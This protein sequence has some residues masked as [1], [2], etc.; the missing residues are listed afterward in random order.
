MLVV[1]VA[2]DVVK[3]QPFLLGG[4]RAFGHD[5]GGPLICREITQA[6]DLAAWASQRAVVPKAE[7]PA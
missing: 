5:V 2:R 6:I 1:G 3:R 4:L 7:R